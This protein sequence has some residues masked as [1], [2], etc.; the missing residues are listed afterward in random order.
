MSSGSRHG[1]AAPALAEVRAR[2][3]EAGFAFVDGAAMRGWLERRQTLGDWDAFAASWDRLG[4]DPYLARV[5]RQRRRRHAVF[6]AEGEALR[7]EPHQPHYQTL[8]YNPLQGGIER[9][10]EP[11]E[12]AVAGS[13]SLRAILAFARDFFAPLAPEVSAWRIEVHQF[14][15]EAQQDRPGQPTPE[16]VH[17]DGVDYVLVLMVDRRNIASGTTTI[18]AA[19]GGEVGSF[20]LTRPFDAALVDDARVFH[21]VTPVTPLDPRQPSH[22]DVLVATLRRSG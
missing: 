7:R 13:A 15:I 18:H 19:D 16:G 8:D 1:S 3:R 22:R 11:V 4:P 12:D 10:F 20:T 14:R 21:G 6:A 17:R 2:V 5:G 9:W